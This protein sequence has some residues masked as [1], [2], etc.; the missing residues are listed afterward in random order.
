MKKL[1]KVILVLFS[2]L[3]LVQSILV[4]FMIAG[5]LDLT[6]ASRIIGIALNGDLCAKVILVVEIILLLLSLKCIFFDSEEA[7]EKEKGILMQNDNGRLLISKST[8][9]NIVTSVIKGFDSVE[10]VSVQVDVD[11]LN[12]LIISV[13]I[14]VGKDVIIKDLTLNMQN[15]I[16]EAV[17]KTSD[18]EVKSV[19]VKIKDIQMD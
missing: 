10:T 7:Q 12:N 4:M 13:N 3:I 19:N 15:K 1:D 8:L 11:T 16:K 9:E 17:K 6:T 2:I 5:W 18:L 14:I